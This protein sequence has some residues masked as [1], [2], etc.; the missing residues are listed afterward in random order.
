VPADD[1][2]AA[3]VCAASDADPERPKPGSF[4]YAIHDLP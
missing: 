3:D 2:T 1:L 4:A